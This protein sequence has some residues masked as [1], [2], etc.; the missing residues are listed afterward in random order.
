MKESLEQPSPLLNVPSIAAS[1]ADSSPMTLERAIEAGKLTDGEGIME[2]FN[3]HME[4]YGYAPA[5]DQMVKSMAQFAHAKAVREVLWGV[6]VWLGEIPYVPPTSEHWVVI[7]DT[8]KR[9]AAM[10][11]DRIE[12][13]GISKEVE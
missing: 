11:C 4:E 7:Q 2:I 8:Q 1:G 6:A 9:L 12:T 3:A 5:A 13:L 10:L